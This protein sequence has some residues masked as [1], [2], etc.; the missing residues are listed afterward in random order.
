MHGIVVYPGLRSLHR[1]GNPAPKTPKSFCKTGKITR[2]EWLRFLSRIQQGER[3]FCSSIVHHHWLW[4]GTW[5]GTK[6]AYGHFFWRGHHYGTHR[7]AYIALR[8]AI[9]EGREIDHVCKNS[10][11]A[12][13][14]C[15]EPVDHVTNVQRSTRGKAAKTHCIHGHIFDEKNTYH[16]TDK[17]YDVRACRACHAAREV[18][19]KKRQREQRVCQGQ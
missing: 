13:P 11:C 19:R 4:T 3:C 1:R 6:R 12:N 9:P 2:R 14:M 8:G 16:G 7:F 10:L 15:L 5:V 18:N 17:G